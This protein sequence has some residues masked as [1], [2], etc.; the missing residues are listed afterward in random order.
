VQ[1]RLISLDGGPNIHVDHSPMLIGR[2]PSCDARIDSV[3]I[4]R[5]H[6]CVS[7]HDDTLLIK[8][9]GST[10]GVWVNGMRVESGR[11]RGGDEVAIGSLRFVVE[12]LDTAFR[13]AKGK[14]LASSVDTTP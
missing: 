7:V 6:C 13:Q 1:T 9:L 5:R 14:A 4:S 3:R 12:Q 8:D 2:H 11:L 10:N